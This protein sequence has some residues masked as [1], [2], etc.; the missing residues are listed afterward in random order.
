[1]KKI[2]LL[3]A[4]ACCTA[5]FA[6]PGALDPAFGHA[7]IVTTPLSAGIDQINAIALQ[8][9]GK[10]VTA[11]YTMKY[12]SLDFATVRYSST[13]TPEFTTV[14]GFSKAD[15]IAYQVLLQPDGKIIV[16]GYSNNKESSIFKFALARYL[17]AGVLDT[18][19]GTAGKVTTNFSA[20]LND[21]AFT[22]A[23]QP[24]GKILVGGASNTGNGY[25]FLL[26]RYRTDGSL[27]PD[28]GTGGSVYTILQVSSIIHKIVLLPDGKILAAGS[29]RLGSTYRL[30]LARYLPEGNLDPDFGAYGVALTNYYVG[31]TDPQSLLVGNDGKIVWAGTVNGHFVALQFDAQG[32]ADDAFGNNGAAVTTFGAGSLDYCTAAVAQPDGMIVCGGYTNSTGNN[33]YA[34]TRFTAAGLLDTTFGIAG[35][36]IT[37][38]GTANSDRAY[39]LALQPDGKL[40]AAG[41]SENT[42]SGSDF[43]LARYGSGLM[44]GTASPNGLLDD[45]QLFPNPVGSSARFLYRLRRPGTLTVRIW[46]SRGTCLHTFF[47]KKQSDAGDHTDLL[48]MPD[49]LPAGVY[50][51][52]V[53]TEL[54]QRRLPFF[55]TR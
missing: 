9:D 39:A 55:H 48:E 35:R 21:K 1:M 10:I 53:G 2:T 13:G 54:E 8:P 3:L 28:F 44:V 6:Q 42:G 40:V 46:D 27:D 47:S 30:V 4:V 33:N 20:N 18:T 19:F 26:A 23:L 31:E 49:G 41:V 17:P 52:S 14:T 12:G 34:L 7:G 38:I 37:P 50:F 11:G 36:V 51:L 22:A 43:S 15:D 25:H 32:N 24:D 29:T 5:S 16:A 45:L